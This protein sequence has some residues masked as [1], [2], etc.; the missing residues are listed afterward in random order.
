MSFAAA[1]EPVPFS[2]DAQGVVRVGGTRVTLDTVVAAFDSG[3]SAEEI[4]DDFP[5][6]LDDVY[7][8][9]TYILRHRDEVRSYLEERQ[10]FAASVRAENEARFDHR[11]LR[12]RLVAR[13][14]RSS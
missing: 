9:L 13:L 2:T 4:A 6:H 7:A 8:V 14:Q 12:D 1:I 11:G 5:L 10:K 3:A